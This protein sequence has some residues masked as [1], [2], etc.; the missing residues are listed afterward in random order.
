MN[1]VLKD[2]NHHERE[3]IKPGHK[4]GFGK[5]RFIGQNDTATHK[6]FGILKF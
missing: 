4:I 2:K 5:Q 1:R 6:D 3:K